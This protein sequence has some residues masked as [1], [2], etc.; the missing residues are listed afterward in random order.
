MRIYGISKENE[1]MPD[2]YKS[3]RPLCKAYGISYS[4]AAHGKTEFLIGGVKLKIHTFYLN[5]IKGRGNPNIGKYAKGG[6]N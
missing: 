1:L 3:L 6:N 2:A 4:T 5:K